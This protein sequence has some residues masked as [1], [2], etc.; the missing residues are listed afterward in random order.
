MEIP[1]FT[2]DFQL[3]LII[4]D[5]RYAVE[6][7]FQRIHTDHVEI[8]DPNNVNAKERERRKMF[9]VLSPL[10]M[11]LCN[12]KQ[13]IIELLKQTISQSSVPYSFHLTDNQEDLINNACVAPS[14]VSDIARV[15]LT[16]SDETV[17]SSSR[18]REREENT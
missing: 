5:N 18:K 16:Y 14:A 4:V 13:S 15:R 8:I 7:R 3:G 2:G 12:E 9:V 6:M 1:T 11:L 10:K 17:S